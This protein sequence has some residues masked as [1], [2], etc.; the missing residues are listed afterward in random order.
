VQ[1]QLPPKERFGAD[2]GQLDM[3][4][5]STPTGTGILL[6]DENQMTSWM[7]R[8]SALCFAAKIADVAALRRQVPLPESLTKS[9]Q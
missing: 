6:E 8:R 9:A 5:T 7:S 2:A 4:L 1:H 3:E